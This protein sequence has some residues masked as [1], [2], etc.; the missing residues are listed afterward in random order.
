MASDM[1]PSDKAKRLVEEV[2]Y[3]AYDLGSNE[4][5]SSTKSEVAE[6][7]ADTNKAEAAL[8]EYVQT[9]EA[10]VLE[11]VAIDPERAIHPA[12]AR[13]LAAMKGEGDG[14]EG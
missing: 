2:R 12:T 9:L 5:G 11:Q 14:N 3:T 8:L 1:N 7:R 4:Y 6:Y 13:A 10:A